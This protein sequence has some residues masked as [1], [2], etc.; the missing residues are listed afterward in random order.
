MRK[1]RN[2]QSPNKIQKSSS[3]QVNLFDIK[4]KT[5]QLSRSQTKITQSAQKGLSKY[6]QAF[7]NKLGKA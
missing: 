3:S 6:H 1:H 2:S 5:N 7:L 4:K